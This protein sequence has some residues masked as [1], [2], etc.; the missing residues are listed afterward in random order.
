MNL[1][2]A[3]A[4]VS[5]LLCAAAA[6]ADAPKPLF[7]D[8]MGINGHTVQFKPALYKPICALVRDYHP[9][10]WDL[11]KDTSSTPPFPFAQNRVD[12]K[13]VYGSWKEQGFNTD[14]CLMFSQL[15]APDWKDL[16]RDAHNYGKL[17]AAA[18][19]PSSATPL[20]T[21]VEIGNEPGNYS[22]A[23]YRKLFEGMARGV[24]E[25]D[26]KMTIATCAVVPGK[27]HKYA[28]SLSCFDGLN[29]LYD[30][31]NIH[32]YAEAQPW[33]TWR[34]SYPEDPSI[35]YLKEVS[36]ACAWRD[37][38]APNKPLWITEFG[39]DACTKPAPKTGDFA[40]WESSTETQQALWLVR[41]FMV[42]AQMP[43]ARAYIYFFNDDDKPQLHGS[44]GLTR[45]FKPKPS[46]H[47]VA[48]LYKTLG[49][50]RFT[51]AMQ[52]KP[53]DTYAYEFTKDS[54]ERV[55]AIWSGTNSGRKDE[56][57]LPLGGFT[58]TAAERTPLS[59]NKATA[60]FSVKDGSV[61]VTAEETPLF[62]WL[63]K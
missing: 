36:D 52:G 9:I 7:K 47:A 42:F 58:I 12:W 40:K 61:A 8:F 60:E 56:V 11:G 4:F 19:G 26:P 43:V 63:K 54:G 1:R 46:Y 22:D 24:R 3:V 25:G 23:D 48:H 59:E 10:E 2:K 17:I 44:S 55:W 45:N 29:D 38:H 33:P 30:A 37:E 15:K 49:D 16:A 21:S 27:S 13:H 20:V 41:S 53:N 14:A 5:T 18:F 39:W 57:K 34:R 28:K 32:V 6:T 51:R 35:K 50:Y 62:L 31:I